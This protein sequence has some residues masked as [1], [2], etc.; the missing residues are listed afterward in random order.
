MTQG[1]AGI[2]SES[3][4]RSSSEGKR[5]DGLETGFLLCAARGGG[6]LHERAGLG[7]G[8][9]PSSQWFSST[10]RE[11]RDTMSRGASFSTIVQRCLTRSERPGLW[12]VLPRVLP[13]CLD[14]RLTALLQRVPRKKQF[15][16]AA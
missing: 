14:L 6:A 10:G 13:A 15:P 4:P 11:Q 7:T 12:G 3:W 16:G 5:L 9:D 1:G 2:I 8:C